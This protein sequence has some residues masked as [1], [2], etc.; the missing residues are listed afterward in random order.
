MKRRLSEEE[1]SRVRDRLLAVE[2]A[3]YPDHIVSIMVND[4]T[5]ENGDPVWSAMKSFDD[6][7]PVYG[8]S[9]LT[10]WPGCNW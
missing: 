3:R 8:R 4:E 2:S 1:K 6:K 9:P 7:E 5:D 10:K